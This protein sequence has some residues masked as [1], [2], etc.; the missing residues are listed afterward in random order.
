MPRSL[1]TS[2]KRVAISGPTADGREIKAQDL[3]DCAET[4]TPSK[5]TAVIWVDHQRGNGAHG[6]VYSVR[7]IDNDPDLAKGQLALEVQIKPNARLLQLNKD[8]EKLFSS[9]EITPNFAGSGRAYMT[10][11]AVTDEPA[12]LG[13]Q[14]LFFSRKANTATYHTKAVPMRPAPM[15][16]S[17]ATSLK[18]VRQEVSV[19]VKAFKQRKYQAKPAKRLL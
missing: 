14:E 12:S 5:Y 7:L 2:W 13:T 16:K 11:L 10:G 15:S 17:L 18:R 8:G 19:H 9:V 4:Y 6:T 3:R 1:V